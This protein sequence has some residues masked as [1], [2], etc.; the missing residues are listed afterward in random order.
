MHTTRDPKVKTPVT[1]DAN[2]LLDLVRAA[3]RGLIAPCRPPVVGTLETVARTALERNLIGK[4]VRIVAYCGKTDPAQLSCEQEV[5]CARRVIGFVGT[6]VA[7]AEQGEL[8]RIEPS[9]HAQCETW[10]WREELVVVP[11][12]D[13]G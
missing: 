10:A 8:Y 2:D 11:A 7:Q 13:A 1:V 5:E 3:K 4:R 12:A 9:A 6:V